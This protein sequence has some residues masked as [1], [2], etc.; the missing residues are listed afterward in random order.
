MANTYNLQLIDIILVVI[1]AT[2]LMETNMQN[3][4]QL[5]SDKVTSLELHADKEPWVVG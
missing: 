2:G 5:I 4:L 1:G 3:Y